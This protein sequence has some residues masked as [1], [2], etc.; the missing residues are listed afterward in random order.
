LPRPWHPICHVTVREGNS[1]ADPFSG[2]H[3]NCKFPLAWALLMASF[4][5]QTRTRRPADLPGRPTAP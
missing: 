2:P 1:P 5:N 3:D 4:L